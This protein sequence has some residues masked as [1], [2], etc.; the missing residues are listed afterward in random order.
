M[1]LQESRCAQRSSKQ[2][3]LQ[4]TYLCFFSKLPDKQQLCICPQ[5]DNV[6]KSSAKSLTRRVFVRADTSAPSPYHYQ[7]GCQQFSGT[8][9]RLSSSK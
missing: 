2:Q 1:V 9:T 8:D 4:H 6:S 5:S 3:T 7:W